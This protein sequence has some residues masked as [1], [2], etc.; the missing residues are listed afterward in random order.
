[1]RKTVVA[2]FLLLAFS[3]SI[4]AGLGDKKG[5][6]AGLN[7][8]WLRGNGG[9]IGSG[10]ST[11]Y[12]GAFMYE[13]LAPLVRIGSGLEY[14][15]MGYDSPRYVI[16]YAEMPLNVRVDAG[17]MIIT[18][19]SGFRLKLWDRMEYNGVMGSVDA[20]FDQWYDVPARLGIGYKF[21]IVGMELRYNIGLVDLGY[22]YYNHNLQFGAFIEF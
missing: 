2:F 16:H 6:R 5:F 10:L 20:S 1:M 22:G 21:L 8:S 3:N 15:Q 9:K 12:F 11:P 7:V 19:G 4:Y 13:K 18:A 14:F 17:P